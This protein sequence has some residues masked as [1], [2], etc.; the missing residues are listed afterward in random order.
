[1]SAVVLNV[2]ATQAETPGY[3]TIYP[4]GIA[5]PTV[6]SLNVSPGADVP[7]LVIAPVGAGGVID[8]VNGS[9]GGTT[10]LIADVYGY[11]TAGTPA[12]SG[13]LA[14]VSPSRILDTR[15][16]AP[17]APGARVRLKVAGAGGLP[18]SGVSAVVLNV[19]ATQPQA[20]GYVTAYPDGPPAPTSSNLNFLPGGDVPDLVILPVWTNG[21]VDLLNGSS[22]STHLIADVIG[23][24]T[25]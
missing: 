13:A 8:L 9:N 10:H 14:T 4:D 7:N 24:V 12:S 2:T 11:F 17:V 18:V 25:S 16:G 20:A 21:Y 3:V 19:T 6:S 5:Q 15:S 1:V 22:G 23:Y